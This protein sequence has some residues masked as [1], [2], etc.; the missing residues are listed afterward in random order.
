MDTAT[1]AELHEGLIGRDNGF[2]AAGSP[3]YLHT[4]VGGDP[5]EVWDTGGIELSP[6]GSLFVFCAFPVT[7]EF[8]N[9]AQVEIEIAGVLPALVGAMEV[10][11]SRTLEIAAGIP[12]LVGDVNFLWGYAPPGVAVDF[13]GCPAGTDP[14]Y[15]E[16]EAGEG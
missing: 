3:E 4:F 14:G 16:C 6:G 2:P 13:D 5:P 10:V 15:V 12:A 7:V 1:G 8:F 9:T 11:P